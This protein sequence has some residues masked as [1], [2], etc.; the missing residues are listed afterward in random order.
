MSYDLFTDPKLKSAFDA[1]S[2]EE[3]AKYKAAGE[4]MYQKDYEKIG[5]E[6]KV[7]Q[8]AVLYISEGLKSGLRP[9]QLEENEKEVMRS[10]LGKN[11]FQKFFYTSES[12]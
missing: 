8:D 6:D 7:F 4:H 10:A 2:P 11:W 9:S 1:L 5:N 3:K 12:D